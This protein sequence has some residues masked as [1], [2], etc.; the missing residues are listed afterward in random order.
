M[1]QQVQQGGIYQQ[2]LQ[3][4]QIYPDPFYKQDPVY[5]NQAYPIQQQPPP[6]TYSHTNANGYANTNVY[7][8]Q[9]FVNY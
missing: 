7:G 8:G 4:Q 5:M 1:Q 2:P 6:Y 3:V 9:N